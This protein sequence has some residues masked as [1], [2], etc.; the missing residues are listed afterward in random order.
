MPE[1]QNVEWKES[2][3]DEYLKWI[4]GFAN[5]QGGRIYIGMDDKGRVV[6][7]KGYAQLME[8]IPNKVLMALGIVVDVNLYREGEHYYIEINVPPSTNPVNYKGEYHYR[9]GSTKQQLKGVALSDFLMRKYGKHWD[10]VLVDDVSVE[11]LDADSFRIFKRDAVNCGRMDAQMAQE[12]NYGL[13]ESLRLVHDGKLT[14]AAVL[15]FHA[16]PERWVPGCCVKVGRFKNECELL[17]QDVVEGSLIKIAD[18]V[19][20][21][22]Y[23]KYLSADISYVRDRRVEKYPYPRVA[24]R[25]IVYNALIHCNWADN[26][27][28]QIRVDEQTLS[29]GNSCILPPGWTQENLCKRHQSRP[30]N[31]LL[32]NAFFRAGYVESWG[33]GINQVIQYCEQYAYPLPVFLCIGNE[34]IVTFN[35]ADTEGVLPTADESRQIMPISAPDKMNLPLSVIA[36]L[37]AKPTATVRELGELL[38]VS[39]TSISRVVS[40]LNQLGV[41]SRSGSLRKG[42]WIIHEDKIGLLCPKN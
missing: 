33:R 37:R 21:L 7:V 42:S 28:I 30:F 4:C 41:I 15:L 26:I 19:V 22:L 25:E 6:G 32:A 14:R 1:D 12:S 3:R 9:T 13:L 23:T 39:K 10:A 31:P 17:Y 40:T 24:V 27:P 11:E 2:W 29:V 35:R 18:S 20:D 34:I 16:E 8:D 5:A 36:E 38:R